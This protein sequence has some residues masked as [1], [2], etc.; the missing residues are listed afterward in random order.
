MEWAMGFSTRVRMVC[1]VLTF[2]SNV[3]FS[4]LSPTVGSWF[5]SPVLSGIMSG[6]IYLLLNHF[7]LKKEKPMEPG[8]KALPFIYGLTLLVNV[9]S[10]VHD[11]PR[12]KFKPRNVSRGK[13]LLFLCRGIIFL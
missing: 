3:F 12:S 2:T 6:V 4:R 10:V 13:G 11:G 1:L 5:I 8:L 9:F 7:I